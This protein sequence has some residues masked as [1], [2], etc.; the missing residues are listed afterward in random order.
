MARETVISNNPTGKE[1]DPNFRPQRM[2]EMVGQRD[3]AE[4][5]SIAVDAASKRN[6]P[7]GHILFDGPPGL[8][9]TTFALC[10]HRELGVKLQL[11][12]G[13]GLTKPAQLVS[14]LTNLEDRSIL[15]IDEIHRVPAAVEEF[16]YTAMEDFR[17]DIVHGEGVNA[18]TLN[19]RLKPFTL[20]GATT[21]AG[22]L[23]A[24]LRDRFPIREHLDFYAD[25]ELVEIVSRNAKKVGVPMVPEAGMEIAR[26]SRGTPRIANNQLRW[27]HDF[28]TS[29]ADGKITLALAHAALEMAGVDQL[30]LNRLDRKYLTTIIRNF[31]GGPVGIEAIAHTM[32][33]SPDTLEEE[34][35][36]FLLRSSLVVRTPRGRMATVQACTHLQIMP[37]RGAEDPQGKLF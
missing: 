6:S 15:F 12:N 10:I 4:R 2:H 28:A 32:N 13:A 5:L 27:V 23:T 31:G 14:Y 22:L 11:A 18:R 21:R 17:I 33:L 9:K 16:L 19:L 34:V 3:V 36:P 25:A 8:G 1:D 37:P 26:R 30:G 7:L 20:I 35:E 24:P 29:K